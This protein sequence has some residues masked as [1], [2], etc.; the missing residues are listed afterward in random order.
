EVK[1]QMIDWWGPILYEYYAGT[2]GMG[3][4]IVTS[5]EWLTKPGTVGKPRNCEIVIADEDGTILP[6]GEIGTVY[7]RGAAD[8]EYHNAPEKTAEAH[9]DA[10]TATLG[11]VGY[12]DDDGYLFLTDR[13]AYMIISG[14]VNIYP[15][16]V[17]DCLVLHPDV[18]DV[19][20]FGVPDAEMGE[21]VKAVVQPAEGVQTGPE[22]ERAIIAY[23]REHLAHFKCP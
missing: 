21:Q 22:L 1:R 7:F 19:A 11:D 13:K 23:T 2:E 10:N 15:Q 14:G 20:V 8:F 18:A 9:L 16:E 4:T 5:E 6:A 17:E 3:S 12:V